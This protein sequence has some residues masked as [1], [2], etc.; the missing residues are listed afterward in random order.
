V[1]GPGPKRRS[2]LGQRAEHALLVTMGAVIPRFP[3]AFD[4]L[5]AVVLGWLAG[6]VLRIRRRT[7]ESNLLAAFPDRSP[8]WRR[9]VARG[10]Y[11]HFAAETLA[12][13]RFARMSR[14]QVADRLEVAGIERFHEAVAS[15][16]G[17]ILLA[18][19]FGNWELAGIA[20]AAKGIP[21]DAVVRRQ[22]NPW[23]NAY[24][25]GVRERFG[26]GV[27]YRDEATR[28]VPKRLR[29]SRTVA[30]VADQ[31]TPRG[32][33]FVD[34]FGRPAATARGPGVLGLRTGTT[35][36][37]LDPRRLAGR[38]ARYRMG[39][40]PLRIDAGG[41]MDDRVRALTRAFVRELEMRIRDAPEQYF[42]FHDRWKTRPEDCE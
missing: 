38:R 7:V 17:A 32:G 41:T 10:A 25:A 2:R 37:F 19:H 21:L 6:S 13:L 3:E 22:K 39:V 12:L 11:R 23:F 8:G 42:W 27:V 1:T 34:F 20:V 36:L 35:I 40:T 33:I 14:S 16:K 5:F 29:E 18:G 30:L 15:G 24:L 4:S 31:N 26:M 28:E 9:K